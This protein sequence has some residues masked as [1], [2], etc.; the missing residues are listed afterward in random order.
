MQRKRAT[1]FFN[2]TK[3]NFWQTA[4]TEKYLKVNFSDE[5]EIGVLKEQVAGTP[6]MRGAELLTDTELIQE[7]QLISRHE[8]LQAFESRFFDL[9]LKC[10]AESRLL[11]PVLREGLR[12]IV[13]KRL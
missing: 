1:R 10:E 3:N 7:V 13:A 2:R 6:R 11:V 9:A 4:E 8:K 12:H 5:F